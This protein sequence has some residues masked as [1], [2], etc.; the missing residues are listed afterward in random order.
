MKIDLANVV[1]IS[2]FNS[3]QPGN[4]TADNVEE[5]LEGKVTEFN[6]QI[7]FIGKHKFYQ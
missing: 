5:K 7:F 2:M 4:I 3:Y 1:C 6:I